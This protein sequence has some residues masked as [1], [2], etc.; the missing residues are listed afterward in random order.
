MRRE[1]PFLPYRGYRFVAHHSNIILPRQWLPN[2]R[3]VATNVAII[4]VI[5]FLQSGSPDG[6]YYNGN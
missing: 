3:R 5:L 1:K 6:A 4:L 2:S